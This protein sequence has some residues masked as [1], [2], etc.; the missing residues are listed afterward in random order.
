MLFRFGRLAALAALGTAILVAQDWQSAASLPNVDLS[1]LTAAQKATALELLRTLDCSC[2]CGMKVAECRIK[3]PN[4]SY[5]HGLAGVIVDAIRRG[6]S[7]QEALAAADKSRWAHPPG[8]SGKLLEDPIVIPVNGAPAIGPSNAQITLVEFSDFQCPYCAQAFRALKEVLNA[9]PED[10]RLIFKQF[11]LD[12]HSQAALAAAAGLA[13]N[14]QGKFWEM[15]D[16]MF[17][18][19]TDLSRRTLLALAGEIG[20]DMRRFQ[21]DL[22]SPELHRAVNRDLQDGLEAGVQGTPTLF[23]DGRHYNGPIDLRAL[24]PVLDEE[25]KHPAK[26]AK[27]TVASR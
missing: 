23:I 21:A 10:V 14:K 19:R 22:D 8:M 11:P 2:A 6:K 26:A 18:H 7:R 1:G 20:L 12:T 13:A 17:Q 25:L 5:S 4:C 3:D 24:K 27:Q 15:H 9:Y 16:R